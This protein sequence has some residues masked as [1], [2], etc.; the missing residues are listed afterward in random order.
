MSSKRSPLGTITNKTVNVINKTTTP[1][2]G[3]KKQT[4][5][6]SSIQKSKT[7]VKSTTTPTASNLFKKPIGGGINKTLNNNKKTTT[8]TPSPTTSSSSSS[9]PSILSM[10]SIHDAVLGN[11]LSP[12]PSSLTPNQTPSPFDSYNTHANNISLNDS[13]YEHDFSFT[14]SPPKINDLTSTT[15]NAATTTTTGNTKPPTTSST[16]PIITGIKKKFDGPKSLLKK[17]FNHNNNIIHHGGG[18]E[19]QPSQP[20]HNHLD[21]TFSFS[22]DAGTI[23]PNH[24]E[25]LLSCSQLKQQPSSTTTSVPIA[26]LST[27]NQLLARNPS[28]ILTKSAQKKLVTPED[29]RSRVLHLD[30]LAQNLR[31]QFEQQ[32]KESE[33]EMERE[34][35][36]SSSKPPRMSLALPDIRTQLDYEEKCKENHRQKEEIISLNNIIETLKSDQYDNQSLKDNIKELNDKIYLLS[37]NNMEN[38]LKAKTELVMNQQ[39]E[40]NRLSQLLEKGQKE[41]QHLLEKSHRDEALRKVLHNTIQELKGNIR[42]FCRIRPFLSNKQIENPPIYNLP[43]NSDNLIDISV[44]SSSAIGT[45]SIK[46]AS[47]TFDK[48]FDT[49]SSQEMVFEEISQLVQSS[50]DGYNTCIF[51]YGQTGSGKTFTMEGNGNEENRGMIPRTV[52]KIFNSAQSLG[53]NGWQYEMEAFFLEIYNE[54]INDLLIVDKVNGNIKYDIRHEGTSITH[55]SNLTTVKVCK[56]EDVFELLGIA[57]KN[58]AVA[59]TLCNDRSSR[60]HSVFQLRIKGTNSITGI[61]TMG[62]L[63]LIDLAGS[64]RLSKSGASGDRLKETQSINKSLSCLSDVISALANKE[65]H[66]PYRNSKLTYLLQNSLGGNSKTLMFVNISPESGDLQETMSSLRFASKVNS[67]ELGAARKQSS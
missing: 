48:I 62:I 42:V 20:H 67:C 55:I 6:S 37:N 17:S 27:I 38:E 32:Q 63:N 40:I 51:T 34:K 52:E 16:L 25:D 4:Q 49:N 58:R 35:E 13:S 54:T 56:A 11:H 7:I 24:H 64:E 53:M 26:P 30:T 44:L 47:Y 61:K 12:L 22:S 45:Q 9:T 31:N 43:N 23:N 41:I 5:S 66:I 39:M 36:L 28:L 50:L 14:M 1:T 46:K 21:F 8:S 15:T 3:V 18:G 19:Q 65:Q 2:S 59:K 60:S 57:S 29:I 33:I 10:S